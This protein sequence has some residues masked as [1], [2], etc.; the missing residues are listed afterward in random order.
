MSRSPW[1][2]YILHTIDNMHQVPWLRGQWR[3]LRK[4]SEHHRK[5]FFWYINHLYGLSSLL[6]LTQL[7]R[8]FHD[9]KT[10]KTDPRWSLQQI[11]VTYDRGN[12]LP[13]GNCRISISQNKYKKLFGF[14]FFFSF[15]ISNT[16]KGFK[17]YIFSFKSVSWL[18]RTH[19]VAPHCC[20]W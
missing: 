18:L 17:I 20:L 6:L 14:F 12:I 16:I 1:K 10:H 9:D 19:D 3:C 2:H 4:D 15:S 11:I 13:R 8:R 7:W 5:S